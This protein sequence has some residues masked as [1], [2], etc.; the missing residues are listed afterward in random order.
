MK[1]TTIENNQLKEVITQVNEEVFS[2]ETIQSQL[3]WA[4]TCKANAELTIDM[5]QDRLDLAIEGGI[6]TIEEIREL[7]VEPEPE[8]EPVIEEGIE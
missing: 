3:D 1:T 2:I 6:K 4:H 8:P 5:W 7:P